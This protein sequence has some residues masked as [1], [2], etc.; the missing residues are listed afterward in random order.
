VSDPAVVPSGPVAAGAALVARDTGRVLMIQRALVDGEPSGGKWEFP[1]GRLDEGEEPRDAAV[2]EFSEEVGHPL[3]DDAELASTWLSED[4]V[5][6][7]FVLE[8]AAE[9]GFALLDRSDQ[10]RT[11][12]DPDNPGQSNY[13]EAVAWFNPYDLDRGP[14]ILREECRCTPWNLLK[15]RGRPTLSAAAGARPPHSVKLSTG[16][17]FP[18]PDKDHVRRAVHAYG[19]AK[20]QDRAAVRRHI[21]SRARAL[22]A[23]DLI[24]E[25]WRNSMAAAGTAY[26][27]VVPRV[28]WSQVDEATL[29]HLR[30]SGYLLEPEPQPDFESLVA[31]LAPQDD[32]LLPTEE[33]D[34]PTPWQISADGRS[35]D[36]H[37]AL[38]ASCHIGF[39]GCV[40]PP[41]ESTFDFYNLTPVVTASGRRI[42]VG[43]VT[44]GCGHAGGELTWR[45]AAAHYDNSGH[46]VGIAHAV[47]DRFGIRLPT[48][49]LASAAEEQVDEARRTPLSGD[50]RRISGSLRLVAALG[51][52]VPGYPVVNRALVASG[53][54]NSM[55][56]GFS[57]DEIGDVQARA[58]A[59][60]HDLGLDV[61][62][63]AKALAESL[64]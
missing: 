32:F 39:P 12:E 52:N 38:W 3:P 4:G 31:S 62:S 17:A 33:L 13:T 30:A 49:I 9:D 64:G 2:R 40:T 43:R 42:G 16:W 47:A 57:L 19:R 44:V 58:D 61:G 41:K 59:L 45:T 5:Y 10:L 48:A 29:T 23:T 20:P 36:G 26:I 11:V 7:L 37:L 60:A 35:A 22:G 34:G 8:T 25:S 28:D 50:W 53:E 14:R 24:P 6:Q 54:V 21:I 63:R 51:V 27:D 46:A 55:Q 56:V 18:I 1:G 15:G